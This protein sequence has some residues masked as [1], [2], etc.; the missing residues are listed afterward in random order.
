ML[1]LFRK[2]IVCYCSCMQEVILDCS[3]FFTGCGASCIY[4]LLGHKMKGWKFI[5]TEM[6]NLNLKCALENVS[7]ND[8]SE[9]IHGGL[10]LSR[11]VG[12]NLF[13]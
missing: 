11:L 8:L 5:A 13:S 7:R 4:P 9:H 10:V 6:D 2:W 3:G 1:S 12:I